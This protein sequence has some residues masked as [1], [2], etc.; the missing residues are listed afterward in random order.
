MP[1]TRKRRSAADHAKEEDV[2]SVER[3]VDK[4]ITK[5]NLVQYL[6]KWEGYP[7]SENTWESAENCNCPELIRKFEENLIK[8]EPTVKKEINKSPDKKKNKEVKLKKTGFQRGLTAER[9]LG[10]SEQDGKLVFL[11]KWYVTP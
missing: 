3:V 6:I 1:R 7:D 2:Y 10:A 8:S 11:I 5:D 9:I 4:R